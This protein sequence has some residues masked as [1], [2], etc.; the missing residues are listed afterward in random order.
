MNKNTKRTL[1]CYTPFQNGATDDY[2][3]DG[4]PGAV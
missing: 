1:N 2:V 4:G 3:K